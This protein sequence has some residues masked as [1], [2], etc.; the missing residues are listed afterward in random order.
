MPALAL[1]LRPNRLCLTGVV[2]G[3]G[4]IRIRLGGR[5]EGGTNKE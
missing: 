5:R 4:G 3:K 2:T 1:D